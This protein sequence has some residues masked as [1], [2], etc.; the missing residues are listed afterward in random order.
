MVAVVGGEVGV[1][2]GVHLSGGRIDLFTATMQ[3]QRGRQQ[4]D[5]FILAPPDKRR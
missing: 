5:G 3:S 1:G 2:W 4:R